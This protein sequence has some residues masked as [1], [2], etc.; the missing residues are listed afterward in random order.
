MASR[1]LQ[2][3]VIQLEKRLKPDG[4]S[5]IGFTVVDDQGRV[6]RA[7]GPARVIIKISETDAEL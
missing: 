4:L 2:R 1:D 7:S 3:R 5:D 6:V